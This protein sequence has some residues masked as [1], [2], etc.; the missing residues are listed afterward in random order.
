MLVCPYI[1][2]CHTKAN[3]KVVQ[4]T[5]C[6]LCNICASVSMYACMAH[7]CTHGIVLFDLL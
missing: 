2:V 3:R 5:P 1:R 7:R 6:S 4:Q